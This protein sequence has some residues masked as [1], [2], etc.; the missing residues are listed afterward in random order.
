MKSLKFPFF[1]VAPIKAL[2]SE[3][4]ADWSAKF[5]SFGLKCTE[6]TGDTD[7]DDFHVL[8]YTHIVLTTPVSVWHILILHKEI[9]LTM[10]P[11]SYC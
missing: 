10:T 7:L 6:L 3:R 9:S 8:Q 2:C 4:H 1:A 5:E 11:L